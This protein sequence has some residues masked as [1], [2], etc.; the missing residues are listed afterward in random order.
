MNSLAPI[1]VFTYNR[2]EHTRQTIDCLAKNELAR[3]SE[4]HVFSDGAKNHDEYNKVKDV[5][6]FLKTITG[7][8]SVVIHENDVNQGLAKTIIGGVSKIFE[9]YDKIIVLEDDLETAPYFLQFMN[10]ALH[11]YS[12]KE[13][14]SVAGYSPHIHIPDSYKNSTYMVHRNCSWGWATWKENWD[15]TDWEVCGFDVFFKDKK[16]RALFERGGND[17]SI[18]LLKQQQKQIHSWSVRFNYGAFKHNLPTVYPTKSLVKNMGVD[19]SGTNMKRSD[20]YSVDLCLNKVDKVAFCKASS[21]DYR[22]ESGFK[23]FYNT[24]MLRKCINWF[25]TQVYLMKLYII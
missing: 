23:R 8:K 12:P 10:D 11:T 21:F 4:L 9:S 5:R 6:A 19:G 17:L 16:Q 1:V 3:E 22:I 25:K 2:L 24:S 18:M 7:F 13:V 15:R 20:K 14:W